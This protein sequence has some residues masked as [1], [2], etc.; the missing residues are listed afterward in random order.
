MNKFFIRILLIISISMNCFAGSPYI[1]GAGAGKILSISGSAGLLQSD[2]SG[3]ITVTAGVAGVMSNPVVYTP[4]IVGAGTTSYSNVTWARFGKFM[5]I[6]GLVVIGT[7]TAVNIQIPLPAGFSIDYT[8]S[9]F[10]SGQTSGVGTLKV[11][12]ITSVVYNSVG[13]TMQLFADGTD[14][15]N[16]FA[17]VQGNSNPGTAWLKQIATTYWPANNLIDFTIDVPI[18]QWSANSPAAAITAT[19][20]HASATSISGSLATVVWTTSDYDLTSSMSSGVWTSPCTCRIQINTKLALSGTFILNST[21]DL[22]IQKNGTVFAEDL[23]YAGGAMT[24][25][26]LGSSDQ[27]NVNIG[28]TI[29]VQVSSSGT[30]PAIVSSNS[31]NYIDI[32]QTF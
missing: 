21:S 17:A 26:T 13:A 28:D 7:P 22:Q 31:R 11:P 20:Y 10:P 19:R 16:I 32:Y 1:W 29:R 24:N 3:N 14:A 4:T 8:S 18:S 5:H 2:A 23:E 9:G 12:N 27:I 30:V 25:M 6:S 15:G